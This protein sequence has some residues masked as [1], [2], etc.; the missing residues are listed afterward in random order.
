MHVLGTTK[1]ASPPHS[2]EQVVA[3]GAFITS[4]AWQSLKA[5]RADTQEVITECWVA[6]FFCRLLSMTAQGSGLQLQMMAA[7]NQPRLPIVHPPCSAGWTAVGS[8]LV[9]AAGTGVLLQA[10][11]LCA[12]PR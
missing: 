2:L 7:G 12:A 1:Q 4:G 3:V 5:G 10:C 6:I 8:G 9:I 11:M